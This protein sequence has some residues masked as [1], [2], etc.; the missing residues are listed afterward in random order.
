MNCADEPETDVINRIISESCYPLG[1]PHI[2]CGG[3]DGHL[4]FL[5]L[6][7]LP[8]QSA[9]WNCFEL[10]QNK[11]FLSSEYKSMLVTQTQIQGG[12][13]GVISSV[14]ANYHALE[15]IKV[16]TGF[17]KPVMINR[18]AEIDFL[19]LGI[20]FRKFKKDKSCKICN[21]GMRNE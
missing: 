1:I 21:S 15:A 5:G 16:I 9:C 18:V 20:S 12:N 7:V 6:T 19:T 14:S 11:K 13:L 17:S 2:L 8:G 3:Y 10:D 4:T